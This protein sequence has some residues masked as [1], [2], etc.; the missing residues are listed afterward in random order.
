MKHAR[1]SAAARATTLEQR[2]PASARLG[3]DLC[4]D[5]T[6]T[7]PTGREYQVYRNYTAA[8]AFMSYLI[9]SD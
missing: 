7:T 8:V 3:L 9:G 2:E 4:V 5:P 1:L 6:T